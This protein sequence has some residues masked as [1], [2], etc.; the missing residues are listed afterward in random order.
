MVVEQNNGSGLD[1]G[2]CTAICDYTMLIGCV[3]DA[4]WGDGDGDV[5][6]CWFVWW[7]LARRFFFFGL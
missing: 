1:L 5:R 7:V 6:Q 4:G 3:D 2:G